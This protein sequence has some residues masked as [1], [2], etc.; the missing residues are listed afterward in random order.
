MGAIPVRSTRPASRSLTTSNCRPAWEPAGLPRAPC[1]A[2]ASSRFA[3]QAADARS[4]AP[5]LSVRR[6][7]FDGQITNSVY[8]KVS[9]PDVK[10]ISLF[11]IPKSV[12]YAHPFRSIQRGR[13]AR[14]SRT[15]GRNAMHAVMRRVSYARRPAKL[16]TAKSCGPGAATVASIRAGPCWRGNGDKERRS[17]GRTRISRQTIA[18][19]K[20]GCLGCT[21]LIRVR[22]FLPLH[23]VLR[24]QSAPG[25]PCALSK[26]EEQRDCT[27][28]GENASRERA[29]M[30]PRHC[31]RSE[32]IQLPR[33]RKLDCFVA[34]LLAMTVDGLFDR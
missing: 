8:Q 15:S 2:A 28:S 23:T 18:R 34:P 14:S 25:F 6:F 16:R 4:A 29:H 9:S 31:E 7:W 10:N 17:P 20:S 5:V 32:A 11:S 12:A 22:F 1:E 26:G 27:N 19:G 3:I 33:K 30:F 21:C 24:A 13:I